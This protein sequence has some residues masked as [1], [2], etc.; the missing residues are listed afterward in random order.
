MEPRFEPPHEIEEPGLV[1]AVQLHRHLLD[2]SSTLSGVAISESH[3]APSMSIFT[4]SRLALSPFLAIWFAMVSNRCPSTV[5][6]L[7]PTHS[8]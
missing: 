8:S 7:V 4:I 1:H 5:S 2:L 6:V 3:S